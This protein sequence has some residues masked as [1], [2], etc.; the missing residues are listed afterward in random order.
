M[1]YTLWGNEVDLDLPKDT[2]PTDDEMK[3]MEDTMLNSEHGYFDG[4][5]RHNHRLH[6]RRWSPANDQ[7]AKGVCVFQHGIH[8]ESG[9]GAIIDGSPFKLTLLAKAITEAGYILYSLDMLGHGYSEGERFFIPDS[10]WTI[11]RDD[12]SSFALYA[13]EKE[14][15]ELPFFL[16]GESYGGCLTLHVARQWMDAPDK[17]PKNFR[18]ICLLAPA[19][20]GDLPSPPVLETLKALAYVAP[21]WTP[22][23]MPSTV[24]PERI[25]SSEEVRKVFLS[26]RRKEMYLSASGKKFC[27][28]TAL[29][30]L[31]ATNEVRS[32]A[33]PGLSVPFFVAHGTKDY[34]VPIAGTEYLVEHSTTASDE[35]RCVR[36]V[37]DGYHCLLCEDTK[38][39]T[40]QAL[41]EWLDSRQS[42]PAF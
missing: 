29:G 10:D 22:F 32:S 24:S 37:E 5:D 18:A 1:N 9:L 23:F 28:G 34:G 4:S 16:M 11:N 30:L 14:D 12:F 17:A 19:I 36:L 15:A 7:K 39:E 27:L 33:I 8:G 31:N 6:Y 2:F 3:E 40:A 42:K 38:L 35:D 26:E 21:R 20:V 25:W 13:E 41:V